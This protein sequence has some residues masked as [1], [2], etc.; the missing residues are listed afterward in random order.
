MARVKPRRWQEGKHF[1]RMAAPRIP[2]RLGEDEDRH[3][4]APASAKL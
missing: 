3:F 4:F 1:S 2:L